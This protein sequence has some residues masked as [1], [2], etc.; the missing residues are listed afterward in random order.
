MVAPLFFV[1]SQIPAAQAIPASVNYVI[2][3][4][5]AFDLFSAEYMPQQQSKAPLWGW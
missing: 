5:D 2:I 3:T 4:C 1:N